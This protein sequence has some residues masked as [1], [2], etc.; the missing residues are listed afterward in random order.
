MLS[1]NR[2]QYYRGEA[3]GFKPFPDIGSLRGISV[4]V[5]ASGG[6]DKQQQALTATLGSFSVNLK[7]GN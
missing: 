2:E 3:H 1:A 4:R 7:P 5:D 6:H